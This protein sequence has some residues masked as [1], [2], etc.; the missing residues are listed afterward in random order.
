[1]NEFIETTEKIHAIGGTCMIYV[2]E[3]AKQL[4][5][6]SEETIGAVLFRPEELNNVKSLLYGADMYLF[7][8]SVGSKDDVVF[9]EIRKAVSERILSGF[10]DYEPIAILGPFD[11]LAECRR[12]RNVLETNPETDPGRL[13]DRFRT[14]VGDE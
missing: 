8:V 5:L 9:F 2:G 14:F 1:M 12:F 3:E 6:K 7:F 10:L 13:K 11:T 4:G